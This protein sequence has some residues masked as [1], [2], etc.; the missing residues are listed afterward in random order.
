MPVYPIEVWVT[1]GAERAF[2]KHVEAIFG[3]Y[4]AARLQTSWRKLGKTWAKNRPRKGLK[5]GLE[6]CK[7]RRINNKLD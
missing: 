7:S 5:P 6:G 4:F 2:T 3:R 1:K